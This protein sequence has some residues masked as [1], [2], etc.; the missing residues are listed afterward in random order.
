MR[1][2][3]L[4]HVK[5]LGFFSRVAIDRSGSRA[6][7]VG[8][9]QSILLSCLL[10]FALL[11]VYSPVFGLSGEGHKLVTQKAVN[12]LKATNSTLYTT[13]TSFRGQCPE[14]PVAGLRNPA[15]GPSI[16]LYNALPADAK[17]IQEVPEVDHYNDLEFVDVEGGIG[18]GGRDDPHKDEWDAIDDEPHYTEEGM[19]LTAFNHFIDI[20]KGPGLFDDY[21][22]YAYK[23]GSGSKDQY[24]KA[25]EAAP[26]SIARL[27]AKITGYKVDE[28]INWW[29]NDEYVHA[30]GQSWYRGCSPAV[31]RYSFPADRGIYRTVQDELKARFPVANSTGSSGKGIPYSVFMPVDNMARYWYGRFEATKDTATLGPVMHA[32]QDASVPHHAA[33]Y[34]G[35]WH[36][37]YEEALGRQIPVWMADPS[38]ENEVKALVESWSRNDPSPPT[39]LNVGDWT[40]QPALNWRVDQLV[41][42]VALNAYKEYANTYNHF[43]N[44]YRFDTNSAR[45]LT[46]LATAMSVLV[47]KKA[48]GFVPSQ[49]VQ[50]VQTSEDCIN[51]DPLRAEVKQ[52]QGSWKIV[53][54]DMWLLDFG[55]N[56]SEARRALEIIKNYRMNSQCFVGRPDPSMVYY[57]VNGAAPT[58]AMAGEDCIGFNPANIEVKQVQGSWKIVEGSHYIMDFGTNEAEARLAFQLIKKYGFTCICFVGRPGPS[59]VYFRK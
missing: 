28:G 17:L 46:K 48:T 13:L 33:G 44:G 58:G 27:L 52:I 14:L 24:Q 5:A 31:E 37:K 25:S 4:S 26:S 41:T 19:N 42:W 51:F 20:K 6:A 54:G 15:V 43:Q 11:V 55:A 23:K 30:P 56:E 21:D 10:V 45:N 12:I 32:I 16:A 29:F 47:L 39:R 35:N 50:P 40:K 34:M 49:P 9:R 7:Y 59:F 1:C 18:S 38:F 57:L 53:V 3:L 2:R 8:N 36:D 22:G